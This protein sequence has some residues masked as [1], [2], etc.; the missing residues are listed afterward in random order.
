M[1]KCSKCGGIYSDY[2]Q[3]LSCQSKWCPN[4]GICESCS[5]N[6]GIRSHTRRCVDCMVH[7]ELTFTENWLLWLGVKKSRGDEL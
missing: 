7:G 1:R 3:G 6:L 5:D 2:T 4:K